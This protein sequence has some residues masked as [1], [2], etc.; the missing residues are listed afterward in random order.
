[1]SEEV[2]FDEFSRVYPDAESCYLFLADLKWKDGYQCRKCNNTHYFSGHT[3]H[4]RRCAKC[5]YDESATAYTIFQNGR[6]PLNKAF[7]LLFLMYSTKGKISSHKLSEIL[8]IRQGTCWTYTAKIKKLMEEKKKELRTA[9]KEGWSK[10][11]L[12]A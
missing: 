1:M 8:Q 12:E 11:V 4:S 10:L 9:P 6:I 3:P 7:Y 2:D 5:D